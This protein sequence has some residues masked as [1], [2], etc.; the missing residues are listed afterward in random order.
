MNILVVMDEMMSA[1]T[2]RLIEFSARIKKYNILWTCQ[3]WTSSVD[4]KTLKIMKDSGCYLI[5]YGLESIS[6]VV[7]DSMKKLGINKFQTFI[8]KERYTFGNYSK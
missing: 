7:L 5:S 3:L 4:A 6:Q 1:N 8:V 2:K